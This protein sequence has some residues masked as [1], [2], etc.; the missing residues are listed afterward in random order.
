MSSKVQCG[1]NLVAINTYGKVSVTPKDLNKPAGEMWDD[2]HVPEDWEIEN[3]HISED[4]TYIT[5]F[6]GTE[7]SEVYLPD[8]LEKIGDSAFEGCRNLEEIHLPDGLKE[9]EAGAFMESGLYD[10]SIPQ[11]VESVGTQAFADCYYLRTVAVDAKN[12]GDSAFC[13][14]NIEYLSVGDNVRSIGD[15]A[16]SE[17]NLGSNA[18]VVLPQVSSIGSESFY[19]SQAEIVAN[20]N[21]AAIL[22]DEDINARTPNLKELMDSAR[23]DVADIRY[24]NAPVRVSEEIS[25]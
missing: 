4:V 7:V 3:L 13:N 8:S 2:F 16:F 14:S 17:I 11:S 23:N 18:T 12:I 15:E 5:G 24:N 22:R 25:L 1:D 19:G 6:S 9:I 21:I 10:I 20:D